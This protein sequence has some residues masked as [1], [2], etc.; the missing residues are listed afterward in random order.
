MDSIMLL[1]NL[2]NT[3]ASLD[4]HSPFTLLSTMA[5]SSIFPVHLILDIANQLDG[6][7]LLNLA[8]THRD[9]DDPL[10]TSLLKPAIIDLPL[11]SNIRPITYAIKNGH[12]QLL[13]RITK[14][15]D[16][17]YSDPPE[18]RYCDE[19]SF[20]WS[21]FYSKGVYELLTLAATSNL[22]S[23]KHL[24]QIYHLIPIPNTA[25]PLELQNRDLV[26]SAVMKGKY[27]CAAFLLKDYQPTLFPGG[28]PLMRD[29]SY[30]SSAAALEF[31]IRHGAHLPED[32]LHHVAG[33]DDI[34]PRVFDIIVENGFH[35]DSPDPYF[36]Q[37]VPQVVV[38]PLY[39]ACM[40]KMR[41]STVENLLRLGAN[42]NGIG[43]PMVYIRVPVQV[44]YHSPNPILNLL[45]STKWDM[46]AYAEDGEARSIGL[47]FIECLEALLRYGAT[48]SVLPSGDVFDI[49]L[50]R[51][52]ITLS[53]GILPAFRGYNK[54]QDI[55]H[56]IQKMFTILGERN[57][58]PWDQV[59]DRVAEVHPVWREKSGELRGR[60]RLLELLRG[61]QATHGDLPGPVA[62]AS[63]T[64]MV[65]PDRIAVQPR[66]PLHQQ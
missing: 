64:H 23:L 21:Q 37:S 57:L 7:D 24:L 55:N 56:C 52:W 45:F 10:I 65:L 19:Q 62:L 25:P 40:N 49:L 30:Y 54:L 20:S 2:D 41:S 29:V 13:T 31:M 1:T 47:G 66:S 33:L 59:C 63:R 34:D 28:F 50:V 51:I 58:S 22:K 17:Y 61:Y 32:A 5:V 60:K 4:Y 46:I 43:A 26:E 8:L 48:T 15:L 53:L 6:V 3:W 9:L 11:D 16:F 14:W 12:V 44:R 27:D 18:D 39:I 38:T 36:A 35:I 42:P